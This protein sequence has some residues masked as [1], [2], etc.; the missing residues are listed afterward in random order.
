MLKKPL[1]FI[2]SET[3]FACTLKTFAGKACVN[4]S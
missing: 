2:K 3:N 1:V 4:E